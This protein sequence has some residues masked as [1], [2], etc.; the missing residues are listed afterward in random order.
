M[1][2]LNP[3]YDILKHP[4]SIP[5]P[6]KYSPFYGKSWEAADTFRKARMDST[7]GD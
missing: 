2:K 4:L 1:F 6:V 3:F 5:M 7:E